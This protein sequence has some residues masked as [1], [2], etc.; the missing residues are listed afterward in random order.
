MSSRK[1]QSYVS[2]RE[3]GE[4]RSTL[5]SSRNTPAQSASIRCDSC[6]RRSDDNCAVLMLLRQHAGQ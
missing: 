2:K 5:W 1:P 6:G 3:R 4:R